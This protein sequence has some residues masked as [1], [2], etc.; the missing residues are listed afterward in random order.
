MKYM[1]INF[2]SKENITLKK[3]KEYLSA[4]FDNQEKHK[5]GF[6]LNLIMP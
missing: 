3:R 4:L 6:F 5:F 1:K 2:Y